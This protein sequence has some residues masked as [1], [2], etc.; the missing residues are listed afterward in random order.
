MQNPA[1]PKTGSKASRAPFVI[2]DEQ[3]QPG[4]KGRLAL[5]VTRLATGSQLTI[6]VTVIHGQTD[7]PCV[8]MS[9]AIHGDEL[10]GVP[11]IRRIQRCL[12]PRTLVGTV[13]LVPVVNVFGLINESRYL[14]DR[15]DLNRSFPGTSKG[16]L[17]SQ[18]ACLFMEEVV[19]H[20]DLGLDIHAG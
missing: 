6:P 2:A 8:W 1:E 4:H 5:P 16:S 9:A 10:N 7:G 19:R 11:I 3:I 20:C 15:R 18:I 17:A 14:P 12:D 13:I